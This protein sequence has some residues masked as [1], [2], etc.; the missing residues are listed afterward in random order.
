[1][2]PQSG[3][4]YTYLHEAYGSLPAF[5]YLWMTVTIGIPGSRAVAALTFAN[6]VLQPF[7]PNEQTPP[8][9]ALRIV[10]ILLIRKYVCFL[11]AFLCVD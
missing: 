8:D 11:C 6:Y 5:L 7:F 2:I 4:N 3:G 1:M 9:A 10:G